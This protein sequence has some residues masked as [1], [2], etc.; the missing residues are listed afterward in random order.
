MVAGKRQGEPLESF[1]LRLIADEIVHDKD[2][3]IWFRP[4]FRCPVCYAEFK[5]RAHC[6]E[7]KKS[8]V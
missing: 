8:H 6:V 1:G 7:C 3:I 2:G 5:V 4:T